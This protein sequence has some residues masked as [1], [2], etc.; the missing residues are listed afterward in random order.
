MT[1]LTTVLVAKSRGRRWGKQQR[2]LHHC[3]WSSL[4]TE[5]QDQKQNCE[6]KT[7]DQLNLKNIDPAGM[8]Y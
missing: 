7:W 5:K 6:A 8:D 4:L 3:Q 1:C 2:A